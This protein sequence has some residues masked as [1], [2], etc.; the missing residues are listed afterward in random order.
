MGMLGLAFTADQ[1]FHES[2]ENVS[3]DRSADTLPAEVIFNDDGTSTSKF[4]NLGKNLAVVTAAATGDKN[5]VLGDKGDAVIMDGVDEYGSV[6]ITVGSGNDTIVVRGPSNEDDVVR[7]TMKT[8][9]D[10]SAGGVDKIIT[11]AAANANITLNNYDEMSYSGVVVHDPEI[12]YIKDIREAIDEG[13]LAFED[14]K[15]TAS[16]VPPFL[17]VKPTN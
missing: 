16:S 5:I 4:N 11:Y 17:P 1:I 10:M 13:L 12:P 8:N 15:I 6:N 9:I 3:L 7:G 2:D 14:G